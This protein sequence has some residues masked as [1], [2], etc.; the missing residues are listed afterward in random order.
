M[1]PILPTSPAILSTTPDLGNSNRNPG[2]TEHGRGAGFTLG[3]RENA[4]LL[5]CAEGILPSSSPFPAVSS[6]PQQKPQR[7]GQDV[8]AKRGR[9]ALDTREIRFRL[10]ADAGSQYVFKPT[11]EQDELQLSDAAWR[12]QGGIAE[13]S[14]TLRSRIRRLSV[15]GRA[16]MHEASPELRL[17]FE[18]D[19]DDREF[20]LDLEMKGVL[21]GA[22]HT[23]HTP[24]LAVERHDDPADDLHWAPPLQA[25]FT[26]PD[27]GGK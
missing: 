1:P 27:L 6:S 24:Y 21:P 23:A 7:R 14:F 5:S 25:N 11:G 16:W 20:R 12:T 13:L 22:T 8:R 9:D 26:L 18:I 3:V 19:N 15:R 10:R 17:R 4:L 2:E